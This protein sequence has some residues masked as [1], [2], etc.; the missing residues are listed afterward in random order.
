MRQVRA[1]VID[2]GSNTIRL[3]VAESARRGLETILSERIHLGL[4]TDIERDGRISEEKLV[5]VGKLAGDC[6]IHRLE[7]VVTSPGR[8]SS[9]ADRLHDALSDAT[10]ASVRLLSAEE[11]GR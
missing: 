11:E 1:G 9:N 4:A 5:Q 8:Q 6:G 3:L 10:A 2:V 7:G